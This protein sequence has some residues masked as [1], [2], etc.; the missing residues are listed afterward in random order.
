MLCVA[1]TAQ[2]NSPTEGPLYNCLTPQM[3]GFRCACCNHAEKQRPDKEA[4]ALLLQ[5]PFWLRTELG[6][7]DCTAPSDEAGHGEK[8]K[9]GSDSSQ[10]EEEADM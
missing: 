6:V 3:T 1:L 10:E 5:Q 8:Q 2:R 7:L 4:F 9:T